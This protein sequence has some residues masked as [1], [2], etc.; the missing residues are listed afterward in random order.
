MTYNEWKGF[1]ELCLSNGTHTRETLQKKLNELKLH[2]DKWINHR[3]YCSY[4]GSVKALET[5]LNTK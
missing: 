2:E 1:Y 4:V 3:D 5:I